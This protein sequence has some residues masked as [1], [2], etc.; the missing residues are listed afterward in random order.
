MHC[1]WHAACG[2]RQGPE[3][4]T[5]RRRSWSSE[6]WPVPDAEP[7]WLLGARW[8]RGP[9]GRVV[10]STAMLALLDDEE[11]AVVLAHEH[12]HGV[13]RHDRYLLLATLTSALFPPLGHLSPRLQF[14]LE[15]R[16]DEDA[17]RAADGDRRLVARTIA[18]VAVG[19]P[20][21]HAPALA[22]RDSERQAGFECSSS[23]HE[24]A[25]RQVSGRRAQ[26]SRRPHRCVPVAPHRNAGHSPMPQMIAHPN[27]RSISDGSVA[28]RA[29]MRARLGRC[30][31]SAHYA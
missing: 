19:S 7:A 17:A 21:Q 1:V 28:P 9:A 18:K 16:A 15:R 22:S 10:I 31:S 2:G 8:R 27:Q 13:H 5:T 12:A 20:S 3:S 25:R 11:R 23:H 24:Y 29:G 30:S 26:S 4:S 14:G 6:D